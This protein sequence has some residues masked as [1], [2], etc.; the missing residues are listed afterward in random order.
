MKEKGYYLRF[1][2]D[3]KQPMR[4]LL[5]LPMKIRFIRNKEIGDSNFNNVT[6]FFSP[7]VVRVDKQKLFTCTKYVVFWSGFHCVVSPPGPKRRKCMSKGALRSV[8]R[9]IDQTAS[10]F[11]EHEIVMSLVD[12]DEIIQE[13]LRVYPPMWSPVSR[14]IEMVTLDNLDGEY[15]GMYSRRGLIYVD[16]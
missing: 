10:F 5:I 1:M 3:E 12:E 9:I 6:G 4:E 11:P 15:W 16:E 14:V 8:V 2:V 7:S 13:F